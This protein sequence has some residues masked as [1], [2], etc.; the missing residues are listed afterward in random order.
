M[1]KKKSTTP[2]GAAKK[3][4]LK[5]NV[6][7]KKPATKAVKP[8]GAK[9]KAATKKVAQGK[10]SGFQGR[11]V[12]APLDALTAASGVKVPRAVL[13]PR[14]QADVA[15]AV[16][17][18]QKE[19]VFVRSGTQAAAATDMVDAAGAVVINLGELTK[20]GISRGV[21]KAEVG[22]TTGKMAQHLME[23]GFALPLGNNPEQC[24]AAS[25]L[26][27]GPSCLMRTL[28]P[29]SDYVSSVNVVSPAGA[30]MTLAEESPV[31][32]SRDSNA[33]MTQVNF[34][35][36]PA[37]NLWMF[38][39][40]FPYP[41]KE[42]FA[43]LLRALLMDAKIPEKADLVLDAFSAKHDLPFVRI[44]AAGS[45]AKDR[46]ALAKLVDKS[47]V[48]LPAE[49]ANEIIP[50][51]FSDA[52]VIKAIVDAG[53]GIPRDSQIDTHR[54]SSIVGADADQNEFVALVTA[55]V[56][57]GLA[58]HGDQGKVDKDFR[59]FSR[60]QWNRENQIELSGFVYSSRRVAASLPSPLASVDNVARA[61]AP[62]SP[63]LEG[64]AL[65]AP[66]IPG[67][68]GDVFIPSDWTYSYYADQYATSSFPAK[69]MTPYMVAYPRNK[70]D[71]KA[72]LVFAKASKK[73]VVARSGGHQ[74]CGMSSGGDGTIVLSMDAFNQ[75][76]QISP[77]TFDV[78]PAV[79]LTQLAT[80]FNLNGVTIPHGECP[81]VCIGGHAQ[82]GGFGHLIRGFG[83]ALDWVMAITI[84]LA[85]GT[86]KIVQ[87]PSGPPVT[88][89]EK[90]FWG[91]LGG[92]A[93]SFGIVTNY[94][95]ECVL[96]SDHPHS[97]GYA[98]TRKFDKAC[99]KGLMKQVQLWTQGVEAGVL[100]AGIDF[101][102]TVESGSDV[103]IP[104]VILVELVH[105]NLG[106]A[107][108]P[109][110]GD[111]VFKSIIQAA[112]A[113]TGMF[114]RFTDKGPESLSALSDSFVRRWPKTT[115]DGREFRYPYKKRINCTTSALS[116]A[117]VDK[118]VDM[119]N[120]V[121]MH[122]DGVYLVFQML[123]GGGAYR[124][125]T[126]RPQTSI[127]RRDYVYCFVFD[128]FYD[129]GYEQTAVKLQKE[130]Q[131]LVDSEYSKGQEQRVLWGSFGDYD[132]SKPTVRDYYYD[133]LGKYTELQKLKKKVDPDNRFH[134]PFAVQL[135]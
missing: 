30:P 47:L 86:E 8:G 116:D 29:L 6:T 91:V 76:R 61:E 15:T 72:A 45:N 39:K 83:L 105:S 131:A 17:L 53:F 122:T 57:R 101:M 134:T 62:L 111:A 27:E 104:P 38:R 114:P 127:P 133:D 36:A 3:V 35:P 103:I 58:Y 119:V 121:V 82:T 20:V 22:A 92:N 50:E 100:P 90:L 126:R 80:E 4:T 73:S 77:N 2:K 34:K 31:A 112:D 93:G 63:G 87:R 13:F 68:Q 74:Y 7:T 12:R 98:A 75:F 109:V 107:N 85:D 41:G 120:K 10:A 117:F 99:Y 95:F 67:F 69:D 115:L 9:K 94:R 37:K 18:S 128:L 48:V 79:Q 70:E 102:M 24:V 110:D 124:D 129:T 5:K 43:A 108:E 55:D 113:A 66:R 118:F 28:G 16:A 89:D 106:G 78:G 25:V 64:F 60:L 42:Q 21:M 59:I 11:I 44:T 71:I 81:L 135:P 97:Y 49:F 52:D 123:F 1:A 65:A 96:D 84:M 40:S 19:R 132:M 88:D 23:G 14:S 33:V 54:V 46:K 32:Q 125:S 56:D 26:H 130:M 51:K